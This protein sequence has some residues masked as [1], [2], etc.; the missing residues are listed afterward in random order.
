LEGDR[1]AN[2]S[3]FFFLFRHVVLVL[4]DACPLDLE[5]SGV[6]ASASALVLASSLGLGADVRSSVLAVDSTEVT[7]DL[8][9]TAG[10]LEQDGLAASGALESELVES[11]DLSSRLLDA[12]TSS[13]SDVEGGNVDLGDGQD[14]LIIGHSSDDDEDGVSSLTLNVSSDLLDRHGGTV[15]AGH[16]QAAEDNL[17]EV[18][19]GTASQ[20]L[21]QLHSLQKSIIQYTC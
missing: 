6:A 13:L 4:L 18:S 1:E 10:S 21:V 9:G 12:G 11:Q 14:A 17:V 7:E 16:D 15:V 19:L 5:S 8:A 3:F 20:E 2:L